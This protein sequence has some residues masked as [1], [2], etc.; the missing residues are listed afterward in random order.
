MGGNRDYAVKTSGLGTGCVTQLAGMICLL[1]LVGYGVLWSG[2]VQ[3]KGGAESYVL[4][5]PFLAVLTG[6]EIVAG[7]APEL[8]YDTQAQVS[9]Q[10]TVLGTDLD[11]SVLLPYRDPPF[12]AVALAPLV[13]AHASYS[14][15]F[16]AWAVL[17]T[18]S[19][20][21]CIGMLAGRWPT[22]QGTPWL[23]MLAATSFL[24]LITSLMQGQSAVLVL[25]GW[26]G[27]TVGLKSGQD[28]T[29][30]IIAALIALQ[31]ANWP[32]LLLVLLVTR[33]LR[34]LAALLGAAAVG[35]VSVMPLLGAA[36]PSAYLRLLLDRPPFDWVTLL[37][38]LVGGAFLL[39]VWRRPQGATAA[40]S[41]Q[42]DG[43]DMRWAITLLVALLLT[44]GGGVSALVFA[45][46]PGWIIGSRLANGQMPQAQR[47]FWSVWLPLGYALGLL[48][49]LLP[50]ASLPLGLVWVVG[51]LAAGIW[52]LPGAEPRLSNTTPTL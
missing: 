36:W 38:T 13:R 52:A 11:P 18:T 5:T 49:V 29:A 25:L 12:G 35:C 1:L 23:L 51:A 39:R 16:T 15:L 31:P 2:L 50:G 34:A 8:L 26:V 27:L 46:V 17:T 21:L 19:A 37:A 44:S 9:A 42:T 47:R 45:V 32:A 40:W 7:P 10:Q 22:A 4:R 3:Q 20:G 28:L 33:R 14:L 6:A 41:P 30:G 48:L 24:P 43:W